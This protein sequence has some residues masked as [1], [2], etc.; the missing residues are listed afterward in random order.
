M[1]KWL[2][3]NN[4]LLLAL[5]VI[6]F[7]WQLS[8]VLLLSLGTKFFS[9]TVNCVYTDTIEKKTPDFLWN[10]ANFDG[11]HYLAIAKN[12]YKN[13][14]QAF[15]PVYPQLVKFLTPFFLGR[16]LL[17][18]LSVSLIAF[19]W[20]LFFLYRLIRLDFSVSIT[21]R[22]LF[23]FLIFPTSF[24]FA[25]VYTE[26]LFLFFLLG[27]F[28]FARIKK[29]WWAGILGALASGTRVIGVFI[30]PALLLEWYL[31]NK[32]P[33]SGRINFNF[34]QL[35]AVL[36]VPL[37]LLIYMRYLAINYQDPLIFLHT[38]A[39]FGNERVSNKIIMLHQVY[40]RYAKMIWTTK[41]DPLYFTVWLELLAG[42]FF[43]I[44]LFRALLQKVRI[45]YFVFSL[46]AFLLPT[47]S[48]T[49]SSLPRYVL[50]L[51]PCFIALAYIK[52][53]L[54]IYLFTLFCLI[55]LGI[56]FSLFSLGYFVS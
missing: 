20:S 18:G 46:P 8:L 52:N 25:S 30:F 42:T 22:T 53:K 17:A 4:K 11:I 38:Q 48:G 36:L 35:L 50:V 1:K 51:F 14:Q 37:G 19:F 26:S 24:F 7:V 3:K 47:L 10:R 54:F 21:K 29:W 34:S 39:A 43:P 44:L 49:F 27:S 9:R 28:Y 6:V 40:W 15:F 13:S 31:Q 16:D 45:S 55:C 32:D 56:A 5:L 12:G 2:K 23:Y 33:K 41:T